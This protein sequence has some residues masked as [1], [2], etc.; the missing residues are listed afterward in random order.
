M[1]IITTMEL[2]KIDHLLWSMT[3]YPGKKCQSI[4]CKKAEEKTEHGGGK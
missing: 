1:G 4:T 3:T 2:N